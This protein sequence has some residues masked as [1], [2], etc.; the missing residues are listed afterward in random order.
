MCLTHQA[1]NHLER[2][3][4]ATAGIS[5]RR[6]QAWQED[7]K[8]R[9]ADEIEELE[10]KASARAKSEQSFDAK[11]AQQDPAVQRGLE[12]QYAPLRDLQSYSDF[13]VPYSS[14]LRG[15]RLQFSGSNASIADARTVLSNTAAMLP[16][17][18]RAYLLEDV[19]LADDMTRGAPFPPSVYVFVETGMAP[20]LDSFELNIPLFIPQVPYIGVAFPVLKLQEGAVTGFTA[21]AGT[22]A[23]S[24]SVVTDMDAVVGGDFNR[25]LPGIIALTIASSATKALATYAAQEAAGDGVGRWIVAGVGA[26]YQ[27]AV[28][29][30]DLRTWITLP[31]QVLYARMPAPADGLVTVELGDGQRVGPINVEPKG[32][33]I[34]HIRTPRVGAAPATRVMRFVVK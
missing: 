10:E 12:A 3:D 1:L 22:A 9:Y 17:K 11:K 32:A 21:R 5:L 19:K 28:N 26:V 14:L 2:G 8:A 30:A 25:R 15:L 34:V 33:T 7:A 29:D 6:A 27:A 13:T 24:G 16:E 23:Y 18:Q 20:R 31:K 4:L